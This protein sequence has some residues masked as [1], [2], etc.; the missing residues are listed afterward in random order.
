MI[1]LTKQ[2]NNPIHLMKRRGI[3]MMLVLVAILVTGGMAVA[4][5]GSRDNSIAIS[6]NVEQSIRARTIAESG[7]DL[8]VAIL[9]TNTDWRTNHID[10]VILNDYQVG[11]GSITI[12]VMDSETEEPPT[13]STYEVNIT[14]NSVIAGLSQ[15]TQANAVIIP[16]D[17]EFDVDFS[18]FAIFTRSGLSIQE[19]ASVRNWSASPMASTQQMLQIGTLSTNPMS[20]RVN[21]WRNNNQLQLHTPQN[22]S[23]MITTM[24]NSEEFSDVPPFP[25]PPPSPLDNHAFVLDNE[26][27]E[28]NSLND[29]SH[30]FLSGYS[31]Y[32]NNVF[33]SFNI[34]EGNY[35]TE[36]ID[37]SWHNIKIHGDVVVTVESDF[38]LNNTTIL[39]TEDA[40]LT[41][42]A[43]GNVDIKSSYIGNEN[44][45]IQSWMDP[46]RVQLFG[47]GDSEWDIRGYSTIKGEIYA[48]N[49]EFEARGVSTICGRIAADEVSLRGA[50]RV[51]YDQSLNQGGFADENSSLYDDDGTLHPEVQQLVELDPVLINSI[52]E[53]LH[54]NIDDNQTWR[55]WRIEATDRPNEV[56]YVLLVYGV[57]A[58]RWERLARQARRN[59]QQNST[60]A[61]I[62]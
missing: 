5:F 43:R 9:E 18:E 51:L 54:A 8:A 59:N 1:Y 49:S 61:H 56:I 20:V 29:W 13:E 35:I 24:M 48:P 57:D 23:S 15:S 11:D 36:E 10:G 40:T 46:T 3:A 33:N 41:I 39:L 25:N 30:N 53:A 42:H 21:T 58:R 27:Q 16:A 28:Y 44:R 12:T 52:Q 6:S 7:L 62:D 55:D 31:D 2:T 60:Y 45:S 32:F 17:E 19:I 37:L 47:H 26:N 34:G 50:S 22:A 4:Y 38:E 14:V